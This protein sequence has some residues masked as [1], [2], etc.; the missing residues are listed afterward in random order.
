LQFA[1]VHE[2]QNHLRW[3]IVVDEDADEGAVVAAVS[4]RVTRYLDEHGLLPGV[5]FSIG[6]VAAL[7]RHG[8]S[9]KV[10]QITSRVDRPSSSVPAATLRRHRDPGR[11]SGATSGS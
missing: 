9:R 4:S 6:V 11:S 8:K 10:R 1:L 7:P 3:L 2:A 5:A